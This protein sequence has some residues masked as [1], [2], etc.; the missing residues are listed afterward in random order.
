MKRKRFAVE[1]IVAVLNSNS[2]KRI[3]EANLPWLN[4]LVAPKSGVFVIAYR[5]GASDRV[6]NVRDI[7]DLNPARSIVTSN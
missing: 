1:Q 7:F 6:A 3:S 2:T 5:C 4:L